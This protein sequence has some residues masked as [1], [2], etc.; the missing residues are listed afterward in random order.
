MDLLHA[1]HSNDLREPNQRLG[2]RHALEI[3]PRHLPIH[4]ARPHLAFGLLEGPALEPLEHQHPQH[5]LRWRPGPAVG[6]AA[7][8]AARQALHH[9]LA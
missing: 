7:R 8:A 3:H 2:I 9:C 5:D 1:L 6:A 4:Q